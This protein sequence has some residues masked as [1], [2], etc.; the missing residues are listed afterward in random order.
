MFQ[1]KMS[2]AVVI[3]GRIV[4][5]GELV[6]VPDELALAEAK[7]LLHR[8]KA[9]L[10]VNEAYP[11]DDVPDEFDVTGVDV[12]TAAGMTESAPTRRKRGR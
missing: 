10:A 7:S 6:S 2:S 4:K 11:A 1:L 3:G 5:A 8:G 12:V 9:V